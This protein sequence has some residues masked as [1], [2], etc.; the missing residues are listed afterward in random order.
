[1]MIYELYFE[2]HMKEVGI[3]VLQFHYSKPISDLKNP[4]DKEE[5]IQIF[6]YIANSK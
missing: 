3:D 4:K 2:E 6:I 1:M 5:V